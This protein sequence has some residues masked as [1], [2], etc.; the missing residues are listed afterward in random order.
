MKK[1]VLILFGLLDL[2]SFTQLYKVGLSLFENME[3]LPVLSI[4]QIILIVSLVVSG[5]LLI[6]KKRSGLITYYFQIPLR[7]AFMI[8]SFGFLLKIFDFPYESIMFKIMPGLTFL[9]E[10]G[11]LILSIKIHKKYYVKNKIMPAHN[12][13]S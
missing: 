2:F 11:R 9:L 1:N 4:L 3:L 7:I 13:R 12:S 8:L 5:I 6:L 10:I